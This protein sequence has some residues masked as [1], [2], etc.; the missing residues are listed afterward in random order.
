[1]LK[2]Q[3]RLSH[4]QAAQEKDML[5]TNVK[6]LQLEVKRLKLQE[7]KRQIT[8]VSSFGGKENSNLP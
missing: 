3:L 2:E 7:R 5:L 1:M 8:S 6:T 4:T